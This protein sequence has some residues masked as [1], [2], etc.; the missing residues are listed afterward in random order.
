MSKPVLHALPLGSS[1]ASSTA[2]QKWL[3]YTI[4]KGTVGC[5]ATNV[6]PNLATNTSGK[7]FNKSKQWKR[8]LTEVAVKVDVPHLAA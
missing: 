5:K 4:R 1:A 7:A 8:V 3:L 6:G 2:K